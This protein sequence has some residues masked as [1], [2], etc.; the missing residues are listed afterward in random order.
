MSRACLII[1]I[2]YQLYGGGSK[3]Y[4][5]SSIIS[6]GHKTRLAG[7]QRIGNIDIALSSHSS[8]EFVTIDIIV[9]GCELRPPDV[10]SFEDCLAG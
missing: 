6:E 8:P 4:E 1:P 9:F 3:T 5:W 10:A 7:D 2:S